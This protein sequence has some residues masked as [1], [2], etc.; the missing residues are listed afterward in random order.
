MK[1]EQYNN[2]II[3][4]EVSPLALRRGILRRGKGRALCAT[5]SGST[6]RGLRCGG[7]S[8][9]SGA[10]PAGAEV[11]RPV[12][13][14]RGNERYSMKHPVSEQILQDRWAPNANDRLKAQ[15]RAWVARSTLIAIVLHAG[16]VVLWPTW[17]RSRLESDPLQEF[18]ELEW[19]SVLEA[20]ALPSVDPA[21]AIQVGALPDSLPDEVDLIAAVCG[22]GT[23]IRTVAE[24]FRERLVGRAAPR[25]T[26]TEP[27]QEG[28]QTESTDSGEGDERS[29]S[30]DRGL[31]AAEFAELMGSSPMD[32]E[33][34]SAVRPELVLVAPSAW[35]L[36]RNPTEVERFI[37]GRYRRGDLDRSMNGS[38]SVALWIDERGSVEWAEITQSSGRPAMDNVALALF[39]E[40]AAFRPARDQGVAVPRSVIFSVRFPWY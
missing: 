8:P 31:S 40:V 15:W 7:Y 21:P 24:A 37:M 1:S 2:D 18:F 6:V 13:P 38:V 5:G 10:S 27:V 14:S 25:P 4:P 29:I 23:T 17:E 3:Y 12:W 16:V 34:L 11:C 28:E 39:S 30:V 35:V 32:L 20:Q 36:I 19:V 26:I 22:S 9:H 33:R